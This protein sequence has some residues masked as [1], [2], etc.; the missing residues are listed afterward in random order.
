MRDGLLWEAFIFSDIRAVLEHHT[1][2]FQVLWL[3]KLSGCAARGTM[4]T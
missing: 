1:E 2:G 3:K 4:T